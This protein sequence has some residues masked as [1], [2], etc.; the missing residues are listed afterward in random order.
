M[1]TGRS[2]L[3]VL[4]LG[5]LAGLGY[6]QTEKKESKALSKQAGKTPAKVPA[7]AGA[8]S[9]AEMKAM[10]ADATPGPAHK[11]LAKL[12][13]NWTTASKLMPAPG[14][15]AVES[16]GTARLSMAL[17]ERFLVEETSGEMM[18]QSV[19]GWRMTG[20]HNAAKKYE[21]VWTWTQAT[22]MLTMTG[23]SADGGKTITYNGSFDDA[24]GARTRLQIG[25]KL[26][27]D[28]HF[29]VTIKGKNPDGSEG[30]TVITT[31]TRKK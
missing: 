4:T 17:G 27:D 15:P 31:Y 11:Q 1:F 26:L 18:G 25:T 19:T 2:I 7:K 3:A 10:M 9:D 28:D 23:T 12:V 29:E 24:K 13:G 16:S 20:Y 22:S 30:A 14:V 5:A 6:A 21:A 8:P